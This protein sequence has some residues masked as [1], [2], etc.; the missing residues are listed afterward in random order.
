MLE[1]PEIRARISRE[2]A[3]PVGSTPDAF[4][5]RVKSEIGKWSKVI[6]TSGIS[7]SN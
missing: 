7:T 6:K 5:T 2:G 3:D 1:A 4:A